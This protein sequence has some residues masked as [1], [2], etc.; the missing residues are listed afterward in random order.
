MEILIPLSSNGAVVLIDRSDLLQPDTFFNILVKTKINLLMMTPSLLKRFNS[1]QLHDILNG[2]TYIQ[3][4][5]LGGEQF[6]NSITVCRIRLWNI[7]GTTE[8]SVWASLTRVDFQNNGRAS[9]ENVLDETTLKIFSPDVDKITSLTEEI[10]NGDGQIWLGG[11]SR[12]CIVGDEVTPQDLRPTG[13]LASINELGIF[14]IGRTN[15]VIKKSGYRLCLEELS[16]HLHQ[17][18]GISNCVVLDISS[19]LVIFIDFINEKPLNVD[20][21]SNYISSTLPFY[22]HPS[23]LVVLDENFPITINGKID[24]REIQKIYDNL[25]DS[26]IIQLDPSDLNKLRNTII[27]KHIYDIQMQDTEVFSKRLLT[28]ILHK[29]IN[30]LVDEIHDYLANSYAATTASSKSVIA[31]KEKANRLVKF[32]HAKEKSNVLDI[33]TFS[34]GGRLITDDSN[35]KINYF[36]FVGKVYLK[37]CIDCSPLIV[38]YKYEAFEEAICFIGSHFGNFLCF[39]VEDGC[40]VIWEITLGDRI[41]SSACFMFD[42]KYLIQNVCFG[43]YD[44]YIYFVSARSGEIVDKYLTGDIVKASPVFN[45]KEEVT[46]VGSYDENLYCFNLNGNLNWKKK[47]VGGIIGSVGLNEDCSKLW[48]GTLKGKVYCLS[49]DGQKILVTVDLK[50]PIFSS[51][52]IVEEIS[53][54]VVVGCV[55]NFVY[56]ISELGDILW[57][58]DTEGPIFSSANILKKDIIIGSHSKKLFL[59]NLKNGKLLKKIK[60][61]SEIYSIP[62]VIFDEYVII[63]TIGGS[64]KLIRIEEKEVEEKEKIEDSEEKLIEVE[65]SKECF[66]SGVVVSVGGKVY[67]VVGCRDNFSYCYELQ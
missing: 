18:S 35:V 31:E 53:N 3:D 49:T 52:V 9:I 46:Y 27:L 45:K 54:S 30:D 7:Y 14:Y 41:E 47:L 58:F 21:L 8:N 29:S 51:P 22:V 37:K 17:F 15:N 50:M 20:L 1:F 33:S 43:C 62:Y 4:L 38:Q 26:Q 6:P 59:L 12:Q 39:K 65:F 63:S 16:N 25:Q 55:D 57:K 66:S 19:K 32:G 64:L 36:N 56:K 11:K 40:P 42:K 13:D 23:E 61:D 24:K 34:K 60:F 10:T 5:I 2:K 48:I 44:K 28:L 67:C